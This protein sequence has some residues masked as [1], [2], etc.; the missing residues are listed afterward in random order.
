MSIAASQLGEIYTLIRDTFR[1]TPRISVTPIQGDPPDKYRVTY[2][3]VGK[4][5][6][7]AGEVVDADSHQVEISIPFGFPHFPPNCRPLSPIFHP[8]FD[9]DAIHIGDFWTEERTVPELIVE[10]GRMINGETCSTV[11]AFNKEA[12]EWY[13]SHRS[14]FPLARINWSEGRPSDA[15]LSEHQTPPE[16]AGETAEEELKLEITEEELTLEI[17]EEELEEELSFSAED[18]E[19]EEAPA[20]LSFGSEEKAEEDR[21]AL[22][23]RMKADGEFIRLKNEL[24]GQEEFS[25]ELKALYDEA[26]RRVKLAEEQ[27]AEA[28]ETEEREE[29]DSA[30]EL[31]RSV[32]ESVTDFPAIQTDVN[33]LQDMQAFMA[34]IGMA[35]GGSETAAAAKKETPKKKSAAERKL[36]RDQKRVQPPAQFHDNRNTFSSGVSARSPLASRLLFGGFLLTLAAAVPIGLNYYSGTRVDRAEALLH[37]CT[38]ALEVAQYRQAQAFCRQSVDSAEGAIYFEK[39]RS[40]SVIEEAREILNSKLLKAG[41][42]GKTLIDGKAFDPKDAKIILAFRKK[43]EFA[44]QLYLKKN[45]QE[46]AINYSDA[47]QLAKKLTFL[48]EETKRDLEKRNTLAMLQ[49]SMQIADV[50]AEQKEWILMLQTMQ[51]AAKRLSALPETERGEFKTAVDSRLFTAQLETLQQ[52]ADRQILDEQWDDATA[53]WKEAI[54]LTHQYPGPGV[55]VRTQL[56]TEVILTDLYKTLGNGK[57]ALAE[58]RWDEAIASYDRADKI[59]SDKINPLDAESSRRS[60]ERLRKIILQASLIRGEQ[61]AQGLLNNAELR[62][63]RNTYRNLLKLIESSSMKKDP[64]FIKTAR[65]I[66]KKIADL[67][68]QLYVNDK[69]SYLRKNYRKLFAQQYSAIDAKLLSAFQVKKTKETDSYINF[70]MQC[71]EKRRGVRPLTLILKYQFNKKTG[72]WRRITD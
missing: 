41:L 38:G 8:D 65:D 61:S 35:E 16:T 6:D 62:V 50:Q 25:T 69:I 64:Q 9:N 18:N 29:I 45:F 53:T 2:H 28:R 71:T 27:Y 37:Q 5:R 26:I 68:H 17:T 33:R 43:K 70:R 56:Q 67:D 1:N 7:P 31:Y 20:F 12:A 36:E 58:G 19:S 21:I 52:K 54:A 4:H 57:A 46:A 23:R 44:D 22:L 42:S 10:I 24:E 51:Q 59:L 11:D 39:K 60:K 47:S 14:D 3:T 13:K 48:D 49:Y 55:K 66:R 40:A 72:K 63:A 30:L 15:V 32:A 34:E